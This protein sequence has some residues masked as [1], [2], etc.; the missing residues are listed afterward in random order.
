MVTITFSEINIKLP[1]EA[2]TIF[3]QMVS[4]FTLK[5]HFVSAEKAKMVFW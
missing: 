1:I 2:F 5:G 3:V 4:Q